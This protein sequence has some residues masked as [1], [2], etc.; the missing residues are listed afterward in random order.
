MIANF[1][2]SEYLY[3]S[4]MF[5]SW[6][7]SLSPTSLQRRGHIAPRFSITTQLENVMILRKDEDEKLKQDDEEGGTED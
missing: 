1:L 7:A 6:R 2:I 4:F 3:L 5:V